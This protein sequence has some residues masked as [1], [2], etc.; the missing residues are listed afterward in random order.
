M[1]RNVHGIVVYWCHYKSLYTYQSG[2][3]LKVATLFRAT[4]FSSYV[5]ELLQL[6]ATIKIKWN[7]AWIHY[8]KAIRSHLN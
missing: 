2:R 5:I 8:D 4:N 3:S 7:Y 6:H 1:I